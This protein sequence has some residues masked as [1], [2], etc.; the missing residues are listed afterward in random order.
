MENPELS[1]P[2]PTV[3][4]AP[5]LA[6][7]PSHSMLA[8]GLHTGEPSENPF[9][10]RQR[11]GT[12]TRLG[13]LRKR[14]G[15][16]LA[17]A[18][19][20]IAKFFAAIKGVLLLVPKTKLLLTLGTALVSVVLYSLVFGWWFAVGFVVL[21]F[22]HEMGHVIQL[23]REGIRATAPVF[24]PFL[25]AVVGMKQMPGDAL[26]EARVG[27]AGPILGT[28]GAAVCFAIAEAT[29]SSALRALAYVGFLINL[30]NLVPLTPFDG[31]RAMAAMAPVLWFVGLGVMVFLLL[32]THISF[33]LIFVLFGGYDTYRRWKLRKSGSAQQAAYYRVAPRNRALVGTVYIG[34]IVLLALGMAS[35]EVLHYAGHTFHVA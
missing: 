2:A 14:I 1:L 20:L 27:L 17:A 21:L 15:S 29:G 13:N 22:V 18:A 9:G 35:S 23:R 19:A 28:A 25:G 6:A 31:G 11:S 16:G 24:I 30:I 4:A 12:R 33:L 5:P 3:P 8:T 34:L 32:L 26:A 10:E 7:T